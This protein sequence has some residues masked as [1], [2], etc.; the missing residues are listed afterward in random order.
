M[1]NRI[2]REVGQLIDRG[3]DRHLSIAVTGLSR[4]GKTAFITS[5]INQLLALNHNQT[6]HLPL[7][8]PARSQRII[9]VQREP[10]QNLSV[11]RFDYEKNIQCL[12]QQPAQWCNSTRGVS[13]TRLLI[14]YRHSNSFLRHIKSTG[15][16]YLD[17]FDYPG[18]WLLDLPLLELDFKQWSIQQQQL[19]QGERKTLA[20]EWLQQLQNLDL[21]APVDENVLAQLAASY[22]NYLHQCKQQGLH[23]IQPGRFVLPAEFADAPVLQFFP[24]VHLSKE[25]WQALQRKAGD[26]SYFAVLNQR[27]RCYIQK[28]VKH[29]Y[30]EYFVHFDR[31]II[32]AD[33][34]TPLNHSLAA[35]EDMKLALQQLFKSFHYGKRHLISRLFSP[36]IDKLLF[37]ASKADHITSDQIPNLTSLMRH[38]VQADGQHLH[39]SHI[40]LDYTAMSAIRATEQVSVNDAG[41]KVKALRGTRLKDGKEVILYPGEVPARLPSADYWQKYGFDFEQFAPQTL[42]D[43][44]ILPHLRMDAVLQFLLAD[45]LD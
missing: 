37:A 31:Q 9:G 14:C 40:D 29:F 38:L 12:Q 19:L 32:L 3:L 7:F 45:K 44:S 25:Q 20:N 15:T 1:F 10:Q 24:L 34:L 16:L 22:T 6:E 2:Q 26:K 41:Q 43:Q 39:F 21:F 11:P 4:S 42:K 17:I 27:Y 18:E 35:F 5:F 33:C 28:I 36:Q 30:Q 8:E 13:E 23:F